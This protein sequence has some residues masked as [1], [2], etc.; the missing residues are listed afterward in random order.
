[1]LVC[2]IGGKMV[3]VKIYLTFAAAL[4]PFSAGA[5][6]KGGFLLFISFI[7]MKEMFINET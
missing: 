5:A 3:V 7:I 6:A 4:N 1:M 2:A